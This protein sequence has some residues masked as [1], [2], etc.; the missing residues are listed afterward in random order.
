MA[1]RAIKYSWLLLLGSLLF[2]QSMINRLKAPITIKGK[3]GFGY[4]NNFLRLSNEDICIPDMGTC[5]DDVEKYGI[6]DVSKIGISSTLDSP[7]LKPAVKLIYS[8]A[9][10]DGK[11]TNIITSVSYSHFNQATHKSYL[12][13]NLSMEIRLRSYSWFKFGIRDIPRYYLRN[14]HDRDVNPIDYFE[15][16]FS[17]QTYFASYSMPINSIP[18]TWI[19]I[20]SDFTKEYFN[21]HFTEFD[22]DKYMI[23]IDMNHRLKSKHRMKLSYSHVNADNISH[24]S[25]T[26]LYSVETAFDKSYYIDKIRG[27]FV[28]NHNKLKNIDK[29]GISIN[30]EK[31]QYHKIPTFDDISNWRLY[32]DGQIKLWIDHDLWDG[33]DI[34]TWYQ[35]RWRSFD[36]SIYGKLHV[37]DD[38]VKSY[39][40]HEL[41]IELSF[42][43]ITDILY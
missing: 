14:Y 39:N 7:I 9:I 43:F 31:R 22:F 8:P 6:A 30:F 26:Y 15:C 37:Y 40:K 13:S 5:G 34:R 23:K 2:S 1:G 10:I 16:T 21:T 17:S 11:T 18:R 35:Y 20:Y 27:E 36:T 24:G 25:N 42:E 29:T 33:V 4:D 38:F 12:I 19:K 32:Y 41:W 3:M 28:Y